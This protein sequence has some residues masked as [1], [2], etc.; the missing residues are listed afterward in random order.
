MSRMNTHR[1]QKALK[2]FR[3][4]PDYY[5]KK[6]NKYL[7]VCHGQY[8]QYKLSEKQVRVNHKDNDNSNDQHRNIEPAS[9]ACNIRLGFQQR[10][11]YPKVARE[12]LEYNEPPA[13][14][15]KNIE[16]KKTAREWLEANIVEDILMDKAEA[17]DRLAWAC[18]ANVLTIERLLRGLIVNEEATCPYRWHRTGNKEYICLKSFVGPS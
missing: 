2:Y 4:R 9:H 12:R 1:R 8:C 6:T 13:T 17:V 7:C 11:K 10:K 15:Q 14:M 18:D 16:I 3:S 5:D